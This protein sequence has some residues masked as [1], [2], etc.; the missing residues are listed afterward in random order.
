M[1]L[2]RRHLAA[3]AALLAIATAIFGRNP[4]PHAWWEAIP[5]Y[6]AIFGYGGAWAL[7]WIAKSVLTPVLHRGDDETGES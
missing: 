6:S 1:K 3:A 2:D 7:V 5:A 4:H